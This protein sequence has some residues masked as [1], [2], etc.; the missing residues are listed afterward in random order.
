MEH[1]LD[2]TH[3]SL[4]LAF[5]FGS[6]LLFRALKLPTLMGYII[7]GILIGPSVLNIAGDPATIKTLAEL[8][9]VLLMFM[10]GLELDA[11]R[12][13]S[14]LKPALTIALTQ[15]IFSG[16]L[17]YLLG[18]LFSWSLPLI[19][20]LAFMLALSSTAVAVGSMRSLGILDTKEGNLAIGILIAQDILVVPM[21]IV[22]GSLDSGLGIRSLVELSIIVGV[23][24]ASLVVIFALVSYPKWV[25]R[26]E[27]L[28]TAGISQPAVAGIGL[29]FGSAA[30]FGAIGLSAAYGAFIMGLL[31]GNIGTIGVTYRQEVAPIHDVLVMVFF[32]SIGLLVD[33]NFVYDQWLQIAV[34][35]IVAI[36]FKI[37]GTAVLLRWYKFSW[38]KALTIS[39][40]LGHIGEF[41]FVLS[42]L[43]LSGALLTQEQYLFSITVIALSLILSP[44]VNKILA[45]VQ[46]S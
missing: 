43:A 2:I 46:I 24:V 19:L 17:M 33:L 32:I 7:A 25:T 22:V 18:S 30:L 36:L 28:F 15:I 39:G 9:V 1:G 44:I 13:R 10:I 20:T 12:F 3:I 8:A 5:A 37:I 34:T 14:T 31:L 6:G 27:Q 42:A 16:A 4:I 38:G 26:L 40:V 21:L 35:V 23:I 45:R 29:C 41:A 11:S